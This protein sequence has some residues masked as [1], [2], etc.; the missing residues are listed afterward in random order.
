MNSWRLYLA[1]VLAFLGT[2]ISLYFSEILQI[3]PCELCWYQR[4]CL[5]SM[6]L[7]LGIAAFKGK[8]VIIPYVIPLT[9]IGLLFAL[10]QV[11]IQEI[12]GFNP[13][14]F[15]G[16]NSNCHEK[17]EVGLGPISIPMLSAA[18]FLL[19]GLIL[20]KNRLRQ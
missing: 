8:D 7:I 16:A 12:P 5:Y 20:R 13:I 10:Y 3:Q 19:I 9:I 15:C 6:A 18:N 11:G 1:W 2:L 17:V 14:D 4:I